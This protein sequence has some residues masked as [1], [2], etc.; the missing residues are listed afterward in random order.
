MEYF[1]IC[2][3]FGLPLIIIIIGTI[4]YITESNNVWW[5]E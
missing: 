1:L 5:D 2:F 3:C 4:L